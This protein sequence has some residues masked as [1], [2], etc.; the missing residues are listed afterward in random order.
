MS[1]SSSITFKTLVN[2]RFTITAVNHSDVELSAFLDC[3]LNLRDNNLNHPEARQENVCDLV[4]V[5]VKEID[6]V[7]CFM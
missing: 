6:I 1:L 3:K 2:P 4:R 7:V 5:Y